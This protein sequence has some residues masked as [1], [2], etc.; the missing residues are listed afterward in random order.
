MAS[1]SIYIDTDILMFY[2]DKYDKGRTA[3]KTI[4]KVKNMLKNGEIEVKVSQTV[5]GEL[6]FN[7]CERKCSSSKIIK[8]LRELNADFPIADSKIMKCANKL[9]K[10]EN[11]Y[12]QPNDAVIVAHALN[13]NNTTWFLTTD[14]KLIGNR[15]INNEMDE[16]G[17]KFTIADKFN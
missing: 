10:A 15:T 14:Q 16:L 2:F 3:R 4:A 17:N 13:D 7:S 1:Q 11:G 12:M 5:L 6:M 9:L 8:L